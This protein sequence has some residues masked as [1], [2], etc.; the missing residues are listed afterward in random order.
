MIGGLS[1]LVGTLI[2]GP[3]YGIF[4]TR[5]QMLK[6]IDIKKKLIGK[7]RN[8]VSGSYTEIV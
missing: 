3:R 7:N 1:G 2:L 4:D 6:R 5:F 8:S